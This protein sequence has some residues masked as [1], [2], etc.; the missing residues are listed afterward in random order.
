MLLMKKL[1]VLLAALL[2]LTLLLSGCQD[3][4]NTASGSGAGSFQEPKTVVSLAPAVTQQ[5]LDMELGDKLVAVDTNSS[6][7]FA[8]QVGHLPAMDLMAPDIEVL[9][10]LNPDLIFVTGMG[11]DAG[12]T[13]LDSLVEEHGM[14]VISLS[15]PSTLQGVMDDVQMVADRMGESE[16]GVALVKGMQGKIDE[17]KAIADNISEKKT[18]YFE[19]SPAPDLYTTGTG[20]F[21]AEMVELAGGENVFGS[22]EGWAS[23]SEEE[24]LD[25]NPD[26][27]LTNADWMEDPVGDIL[28]R[29]AW[30]NCTAVKDGAVYLIDG[31][32]SSQPNTHVVEA[33][34]E[35]AK[36]L[37]PEEY[38]ALTT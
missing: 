7:M 23:V 14:T 36:A 30:S 2:A 10:E 24:V 21:L 26:V 19:I 11:T 20:T 6:W 8:D 27:I 13:A 16:K 9:L 32:T 3:T 22:L 5:L 1:H 25:K 12:G 28:A 34:V 38:A 15:S 33:M 35:I 31:N 4:T 29:P 37:Y 18:V 17:V